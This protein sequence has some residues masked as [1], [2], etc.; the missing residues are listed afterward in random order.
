[1]HGIC[2]YLLRQHFYVLDMV[3][4]KNDI[5]IGVVLLVLGLHCFSVSV[6]TFNSIVKEELID[7]A[8]CFRL[9][10]HPETGKIRQIDFS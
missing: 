5:I 3:R 8:F 7:H 2:T 4:E 6:L 1:M 10:L 9:S